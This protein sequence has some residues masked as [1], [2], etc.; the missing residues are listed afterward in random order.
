PAPNSR[1]G[2][3]GGSYRS[4][5]LRL[6]SGFR[7]TPFSH[8]LATL[9]HPF[10]ILSHPFAILSHL[11]DGADKDHRPGRLLRRRAADRLDADGEGC[12]FAQIGRRRE[13]LELAGRGNYAQRARPSRSGSNGP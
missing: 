1:P 12:P 5:A 4:T 7:P 8:P 3:H 6:I 13:K 10:A 9:S 11:L 2:L